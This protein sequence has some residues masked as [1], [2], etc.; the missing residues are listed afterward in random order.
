MLGCFRYPQYVLPP[1]LPLQS[2]YNQVA[3][4]RVL[5]SVFLYTNSQ[6]IAQALSL[7]YTPTLLVLKDSTQYEYKGLLQRGR[8]PQKLANIL[9]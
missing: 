3:Q 9:N 5:D 8:G 2:L 7:K 6:D 1:S 4:E